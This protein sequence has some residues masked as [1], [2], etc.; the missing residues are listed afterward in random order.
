MSQIIELDP[1]NYAE[2]VARDG[3]VLVDAWAA[4]C[5]PC[6]AFAPVFANAARIHR[7]HL[8]TKLDTEAHPELVES[9]EIT[10]IPTLLIYRDGV[11]L[12]HKAGS[13]SAES[14]QDLIKQ[15]AG[16]DMDAVRR[17]QGRD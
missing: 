4:W 17:E 10:H 6:R 13:P 3:L 2:T 12:Y 9:L 11:L 8:F 15:I 7:D 14:L 1:R 5:G 16:L